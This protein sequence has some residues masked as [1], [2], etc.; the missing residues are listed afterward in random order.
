MQ[1]KLIK[2]NLRILKILY[3]CIASSS[4]GLLPQGRLVNMNETQEYSVKI[5]LNQFRDFLKIKM[6]KDHTHS[7][8]QATSFRMS[9]ETRK[10]MKRCLLERYLFCFLDK[11]QEL[12][13]M[14]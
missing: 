14:I 11:K 6:Y 10:N 8:L 9:A 5:L 3:A 13:E 1:F 4:N 12:P 2:G 7:R